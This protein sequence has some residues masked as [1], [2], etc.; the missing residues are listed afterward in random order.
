[1]RLYNK[2]YLEDVYVLNTD[3][4]LRIFTVKMYTMSTDETL[5]L[6]HILLSHSGQNLLVSFKNL[7][8]QLFE[9]IAISFFFI[10]LQTTDVMTL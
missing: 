1:M 8:T 5:T 10:L 6:W 2:V 9:L 4:S 7:A 3:T